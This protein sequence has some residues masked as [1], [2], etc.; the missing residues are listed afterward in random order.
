MADLDT[1]LKRAS[2]LAFRFSPGRRL[3]PPPTGSDADSAAERAMLLG[4]YRSYIG[5]VATGMI[6][7]LG[8]GRLVARG[9]LWVE[10]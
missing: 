7:R 1:A 2:G 10:S 8:T 9:A 6:R 4:G 3:L 5:T